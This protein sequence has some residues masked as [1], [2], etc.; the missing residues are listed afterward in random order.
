MEKYVELRI[1]LF[2]SDYLSTLFSSRALNKWLQAKNCLP[3]KTLLIESGQNI[4]QYSS[5]FLG[6]YYQTVYFSDY[7]SIE[8][9]TEYFKLLLD[10]AKHQKQLFL[11]GI[12]GDDSSST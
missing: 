2:G 7:S 8:S 12:F 10:S 11:I 5:N 4:D 6:H 3:A 9:A 1:K